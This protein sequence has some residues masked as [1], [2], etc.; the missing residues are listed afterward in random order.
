MSKHNLACCDLKHSTIGAEKSYNF[1]PF[2][3]KRNLCLW[4][5]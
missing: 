5:A 4:A 2:I 1:N 3:L